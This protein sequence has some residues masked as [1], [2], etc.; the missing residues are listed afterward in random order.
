MVVVVV[1]ALP[2]CLWLTNYLC[3]RL[4]EALYTVNV[5]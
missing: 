2:T 4:S 3:V 5:V 1:L